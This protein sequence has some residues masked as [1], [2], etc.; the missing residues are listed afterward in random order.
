[1]IRVINNFIL[2]KPIDPQDQHQGIVI[3]DTVRERMKNAPPEG[4]VVA[5]GPGLLLPTGER[6]PLS[7]KPGDVILLDARSC[8]RFVDGEEDYAIC[9]EEAIMGVRE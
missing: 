4:E 2:F 7:V 3:P 1:M 6:V 9:T 5:V 8:R